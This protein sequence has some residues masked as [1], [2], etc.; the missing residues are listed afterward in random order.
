MGPGPVKQERSVNE[1]DSQ[2]V[3]ELLEK[4]AVLATRLQKGRAAIRSEEAEQGERADYYFERWLSFL[5]DSEQTVDELRR[6]G[7]PEEKIRALCS[8][9]GS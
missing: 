4:A 2:R 3:E 6:L 5:T 8:G 9:S 1:S 7:A